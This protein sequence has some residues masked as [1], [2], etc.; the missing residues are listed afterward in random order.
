MAKAG[1]YAL[2]AS[3]AIYAVTRTEADGQT[4]DGSKHSYSIT[5]P[6]EQLP[7]A[8]ILLVADHV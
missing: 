3:E 4:L 1:I 7:P 6:A 5:F 2:D 8:E